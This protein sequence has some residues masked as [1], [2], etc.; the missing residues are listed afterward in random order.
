MVVRAPRHSLRVGPFREGAFPSPLHSRRNAS[1]LGIALGVSF[2]VCFVTGVLSHLVQY[3]PTWFEWPSRP[4]GVYRVT[5]GLHVATGIASIP[6]LLAKLWTVYPRLWT[7]PP[8]RNLAHLLERVSI[9][10]LV[11]G[12]LFLLFTGVASIA[13]WHPWA[14]SFPPAH[15]A[16][17]WITIGALVIHVG[18]KLPVVRESLS[19][20]DVELV[21][22]RSGRRPSHTLSRRGFLGAV[23]AAVGVLS[24]STLGQTFRPLAW[25]GVLAPRDPRTGPQGVPVNKTADVAGVVEAATSPSYRLSVTGAVERPLS[26]SLEELRA[27]PQREAVLPIACVDGWSAS[28][29][30]RGVSVPNLLAMTGA[31]DDAEVEIRSLQGPGAAYSSSILNHSHASDADTLLALDLNGEPLHIDHGFPLRLIGPNRPGVMQ[32][33]W[34]T[35]VVVL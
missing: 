29:R 9:V 35:E 2:S 1:W 20:K 13:R 24:L 4:A 16:A 18:A 17:A 27:L 31:P 26:L 15:Y 32:T 14:F 5:Q 19:R 25:L 23:A 34:V 21:A 30:W 10:P 7:W 11:G 22:E 12:S 3:P 6:L 28:A 33:K 8:V